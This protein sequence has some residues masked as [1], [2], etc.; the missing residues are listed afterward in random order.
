MSNPVGRARLARRVVFTIHLIALV[1]AAL[2]V[3][4]IAQQRLLTIGELYDPDKKVDFTGTPARGLEWIDDAS[5]LWPR[6]GADSEPAHLLR[7]DAVSGKTVPF[8]D[9]EKMEKALAAMPGVEA[10]EARRLSRRTA[11]QMNAVR[12]ALLLT[13]GGDL[14]HY[15]LAAGRVSRLTSAPGE[16][17]DP[18]FSPDGRLVAF[19]RDHD[20]YVVDV[21]SGRER[22]LTTDGGPKLLNGRLDWVYQEEIYGRGQ[23][24]AFWWSPDSTRLAF[25]QLDQ[26][27]VPTFAL[28]DHIPLRQEV[29]IV[30]YPK[31][32]DPNPRARLG[33][34]RSSGGPVQWVD[35]GTYSAHEHLIVDVNWTPDSRRV[36][37]Q[38]QDREQTWLDLNLADPRTGASQTLFRETTKAWVDR[39][40]S[41]TW[42]KDGSFLW[43][44]E[45]A[46]WKHLYHYQ[47][48][49]ALERQ[50]TAGEWEARTLH[51]VDE[52][53][54]WVYFAGTERSPIGADLYR[55]RLDGSGLQ[56]VSQAEGTHTAVFNPSL[57]LYLGTWST[58]TTPPQVRLHRAD[59]T[60][61][62]L[63]HEN[64]I[65]A[66]ADYRLSRPEFVQVPTRDG[67]MMEAL[68]IKP[69]D[70]DPA[71][72]YPVY[73]HTYAGPHAQQV[74]NGWGGTTYLYHQLLAQQ[75]I[76]V[77]VCDNRSAS[78][79]GAQSA[80]AAYLR[81]G[82]S[83]LQDIEDCLGWLKQQPWVDA[84]RIGINGWSYGGFMVSY[85]LTHSESFVMGI[86]GGSVTDW[87]LYDTIYTERF[88]RMPQNN[89]D[90]YRR[91]SPLLAAANLHGALLLV[92]GTLDDNVHLQN[93]V[94]FAYELQKAG[95]P[96]ELMLYPRS[97][98]GISDPALV[99]HMRQTMFDF[100]LRHLR[101]NDGAR[102]ASP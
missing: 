96:F 83:E 2:P 16:P 65:A 75:D 46:G 76:V 11:Y 47:P 85:A 54:G 34:V 58:I 78:G 66:L 22:R 82:E 14:Y 77:W 25:L 71:R 73:Q 15:D 63:V 72:R 89:P 9:S 61:V 92:H 98:H 1:I 26:G 37:H 69:P 33:V 57:T 55:V 52:A 12:T 68:L 35:T 102:S 74:R 91:T 64:R 5:F 45:R 3:A 101:P 31:P 59:G 50:V 17:L 8:L 99:R 90:G 28:I 51:G 39:H 48:D 80:W 93:T 67:F 32:G 30:E 42:L 23:F 18:A 62:R 49:G 97:R 27:L 87:T 41:P 13:I 79:K 56:R 6:Q 84:S 40:E 81:L 29:E 21:A 43:F 88:M 20:L 19:T 36:V 24:R 100:V 4:A 94:R 7:V 95:K 38:V 60:E 53:G 10:D 86:A 44:S 70:F